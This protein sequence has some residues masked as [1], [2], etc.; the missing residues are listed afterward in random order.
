MRRR[1]S[2]VRA[3]LPVDPQLGIAH[4]ILGIVPGRTIVCRGVP[5]DVHQTLF[6][7]FSNSSWLFRHIFY[8]RDGLQRWLTV[9]A[10]DSSGDIEVMFMQ[11]Y[12][13]CG[14]IPEDAPP[15]IEVDG[16]VFEYVRHGEGESVSYSDHTWTD[17]QPT[18]RYVYTNGGQFMTFDKFGDSWVVGVGSRLDLTEIRVR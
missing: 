5:Y 7:G 15:Q 13:Y 10:H 2:E 4:D 16:Q 8:D 17:C 3:E 11:F 6:V 9:T 12:P 14:F 1:S 18:V